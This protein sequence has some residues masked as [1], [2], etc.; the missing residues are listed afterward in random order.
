[1]NTTE[2]IIAAA[3]KDGRTTLT[4]IESKQIISGEAI[5]VVEARLA[6]TKKQA[7]ALAREIG[8]PVVLKIVSPQIIHK[9]D[10]GGVK[11]G[12][13]NPAQ[14]G[15]AYDAIMASVSE[16]EP[17]ARIEGIAVQKMA[18][19]GAEV[20]IG[21][22]KDVQ[23]GPVLMFGLGGVFVEVLKD[24]SFRI[25]P[26]SRRDA[27]QMIEEIRGYPVLKGY[28]GSEAADLAALED[29]L[30]KLSSLVERTPEIKEVDLNPIVAYADGAVAADARI[31]LEPSNN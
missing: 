14:V 29:M 8:F 27:R 19:P 28:R 25:V 20:I 2:K 31:I 3:Q 17:K 9:S 13:E 7:V 16:R 6:T 22:S 23:F 30:L 15:R 1:V 11:L 10:I 21:M 26:I 12:L 4:E 18:R 5:G 24:V